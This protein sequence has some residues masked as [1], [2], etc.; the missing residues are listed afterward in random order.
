M[1]II[2]DANAFSEYVNGTSDMQPVLRW[3]EGAKGVKP[4]GKLVYSPTSAIKKEIRKHAKF[5]TDQRKHIQECE[6]PTLVDTG[7]LSIDLY[8][9]A[10]VVDLDPGGDERAVV[11][12]QDVGNGSSK[13]SNRGWSVE[14]RRASSL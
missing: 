11:A 12:V 8:L 4:K 10:E 2:L 7:S 13:D 3:L 9:E 14:A 6:P 5:E 1:C